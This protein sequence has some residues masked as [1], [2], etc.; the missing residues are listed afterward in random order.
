VHNVLLSSAVIAEIFY[1]SG[2]TEIGDFSKRIMLKEEFVGGV[3]GTTVQAAQTRP[4][5]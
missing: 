2:I 5:P 3:I 1:L 4:G